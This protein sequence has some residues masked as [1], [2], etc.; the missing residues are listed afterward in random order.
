MIVMAGWLELDPSLRDRALM[1]GAEIVKKALQVKSYRAYLWE[2][3]A[4]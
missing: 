4:N 3:I 2:K 1:K